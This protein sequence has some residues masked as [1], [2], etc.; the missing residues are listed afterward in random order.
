MIYT[1][2]DFAKSFVMKFPTIPIEN[3]RNNKVFIDDKFVMPLETYISNHGVVRIPCVYEID[4]RSVG[5]RAEAERRGLAIVTENQVP[6]AGFYYD[7]VKW[8]SINDATEIRLLAKDTWVKKY[9]IC[10]VYIERFHSEIDWD[11]SLLAS[12]AFSTNKQKSKKLYSLMK[13]GRVQFIVT[14]EE[15]EYLETASDDSLEVL[16]ALYKK[17]SGKPLTFVFKEIN[18]LTNF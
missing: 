6:M 9:Q 16:I 17:V 10:P 11:F 14:A 15:L 1:S 8:Y 13:G 5:S 18:N 12:Y 3:V 7:P 2:Q 4:L